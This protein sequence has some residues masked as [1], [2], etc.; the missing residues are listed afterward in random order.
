MAGKAALPRS[1]SLLAGSEI[2]NSNLTLLNL[3]VNREAQNFEFQ[4]KRELLLENTVLRLN[5]MI[6]Q[7][8][9]EGTWDETA[10]AKRG[11]L[12]ASEALSL[13]VGPPPS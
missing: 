6:T 9:R 7:M 12:L 10:I 1:L 4:R 13:W 5:T 11:A 2:P 8:T 3:S